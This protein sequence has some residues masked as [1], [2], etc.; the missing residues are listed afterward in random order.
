[1]SRRIVVIAA[2]AAGMSHVTQAGTLEES[3][4]KLPDEERARQACILKGIDLIRKEKRLA[5]A[6]RIKTSIF[7]GASFDGTLVVSKGGAVRSDSRW[8]HL[9]FTCAVAPDLKHATTF[10]Y[11]IGEEIPET[12]WEDLGLWK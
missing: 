5:H 3:F 7:S 12:A 10:D 4:D 11:A 6:D 2:L 9:Q 1:M 8:Y